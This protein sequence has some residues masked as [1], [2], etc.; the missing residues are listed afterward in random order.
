LE[1]GT[2]FLE[3]FT[4]FLQLL[5]PTRGLII[6]GVIL[7]WR[8]YGNWRERRDR[9]ELVNTKEVELQR[10]AGE[11]RMYRRLYFRTHGLTEE[12]IDKLLAE[13][14]SPTPVA[15]PPT[16]SLPVAEPTT[17]KKKRG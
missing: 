4:K 5:G 16:P 17:S 10:M 8:L 1:E 13:G 12:Q 11:L 2:R 6:L 14:S 9:R 15:F 7:A 3:A